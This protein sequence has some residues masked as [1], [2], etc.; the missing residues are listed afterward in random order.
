LS[1]ALST[2]SLNSHTIESCRD[3]P[4]SGRTAAGD[5][6]TEGVL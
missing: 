1:A 4:R 5:P 3:N 2:S 6:M